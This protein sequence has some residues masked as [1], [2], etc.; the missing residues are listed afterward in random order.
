M[1]K[2]NAVKE[3][4]SESPKGTWS[5]DFSSDDS[6]ADFS[7]ASDFSASA[8]EYVEEDHVSSESAWVERLMRVGIP[9]ATREY[10]KKFEELGKL[11]KGAYGSVFLVRERHT[12]RNFAMKRVNVL[13][14]NAWLRKDKNEKFSKSPSPPPS[15][16]HD[17]PC[18][19]LLSISSSASSPTD[20]DAF[21]CHHGDPVWTKIA[22]R[23]LREVHAM[24]SIGQHQ[25]LVKFYHS[26]LEISPSIS[27]K[28]QKSDQKFEKS[29]SDISSSTTGIMRSSAP[30][31]FKNNHEDYGAQ[32]EIHTT[33]SMDSI[34]KENSIR[35]DDLQMSESIE[36]LGETD[37]SSLAEENIN[38]NFGRSQLVKSSER[39]FSKI[40]ASEASM[41]KFQLTLFIQMELCSSD[42][43]HSWLRAP[44]REAVDRNLSLKL[45]SQLLTALTHIHEQGFFHR[46]IKPDN[47]MIVY[48]GVRRE[49]TLKLGDFGLSKRILAHPALTASATVQR[50][51]RGTLTRTSSAIKRD[52]A[53]KFWTPTK[54]T[55]F[56]VPSGLRSHSHNDLRSLALEETFD[57]PIPAETLAEEEE[58]EEEIL[59]GDD[60]ARSAADKLLP[61]EDE[62]K[63]LVVRHTKGR[64]TAMYMAPELWNGQKYDEKVDVYAAGIVLFELFHTW[65]TGSERI[66]ALRLLKEQRE[67]GETLKNE[68]PEVGKLV[69][70]MTHPKPS[71]RPKAIDILSH[72]A[73]SKYILTATTTSTVA[74]ILEEES[75]SCSSSVSSSE[76]SEPLS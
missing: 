73:F 70:A 27:K 61:G 29:K 19:S 26:W 69:L 13:L 30:G 76:P 23:I 43:L 51:Q 55:R 71:R 33:D 39:W 63:A 20:S 40:D 18:P 8:R 74:Q 10:E 38:Y 65:K 11:G 2:Q 17:S 28:G 58:N 52:A 41:P 9:V 4:E 75:E 12:N 31:S 54:K 60:E 62:L 67:V 25:N 57:T 21:S 15:S 64:G 35:S 22:P 46:D 48:E 66:A 24:S 5:D 3:E 59:E 42:S 72:P 56:A 36:S 53:P 37:D 49:P 68:F 32:L 6:A 44:S 47:L 1:W 14:D 50:R 45:F 16:A 7:A 34:S